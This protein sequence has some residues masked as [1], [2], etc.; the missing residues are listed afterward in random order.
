MSDDILRQVKGWSGMDEIDFEREWKN[1]LMVGIR[2][3]NVNLDK[4]NKNIEML[5]DAIVATDLT[6]DASFGNLNKSV[7]EISEMALNKKFKSD[8]RIPGILRG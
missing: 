4:L 2:N 5:A 6:I 1:A 7:R 3:I 8:S